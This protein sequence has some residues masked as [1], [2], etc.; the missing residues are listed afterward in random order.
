MADTEADTETV[1]ETDH[2]CSLFIMRLFGYCDRMSQVSLQQN[3]FGTKNLLMHQCNDFPLIPSLG[4]IYA[5]QSVSTLFPYPY[6]YPYCYLS[7]KFF[8][9]VMASNIAYIYGS[10]SIRETLIETVL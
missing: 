4:C 3:T 2:F 1:S 9:N 7:F 10:G 5:Q 6:R 8:L